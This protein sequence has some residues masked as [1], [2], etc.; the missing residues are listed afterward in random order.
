LH[1]EIARDAKQKTHVAKLRRTADD[2]R[3]R[4]ARKLW[5]VMLLLLTPAVAHADTVEGVQTGFGSLPPG[6]GFCG[7]ALFVLAVFSVEFLVLRRQLTRFSIPPRRF[8]LCFI[9]VSALAWTFSLEVNL[10]LTKVLESM[11]AFESFASAEL[12][13]GLAALPV[14][15]AIKVVT[16]HKCLFA[17][18]ER[19]KPWLLFKPVLRSS[20]A[21]FAVGYVLSRGMW[22]MLFALAK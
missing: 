1:R 7:I 3:V 20:F 15:M 14:A 11:V 9:G 17:K 10:V 18:S 8:I 22:G 6:L 16:Y 2:A 4:Y 19:P 13:C 5:L 21:S 12:I